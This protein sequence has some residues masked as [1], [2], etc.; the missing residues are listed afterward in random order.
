LSLRDAS[1]AC[2]VSKDKGIPPFLILYSNGLRGA[3]NP[4]RAAVAE[5]FAAVL[6]SAGV[7]AEVVDASDRNHGEINQRFGAPEDEK[8]TNRAMRFLKN[9]RSGRPDTTR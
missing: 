3:R 9:I 4:R 2:H 7:A 5:E 6:R 1:P 8:V